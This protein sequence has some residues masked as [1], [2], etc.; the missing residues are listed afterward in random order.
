MHPS[1]TPSTE[2]VT[3]AEPRPL[4]VAVLTVFCVVATVIALSSAVSLLWPGGPLEPMWRLNPPARAGF[5]SMGP[6]AIVLLGTVAI[7]S[8]FSAVGLWRGR[9][10]GRRVVVAGIALN[11]LADLTNA[12]V[13]HDAR[14][15]IGV[16]VAAVVIAYLCS[17]PVRRYF[18]KSGPKLPA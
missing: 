15:L 16:P 14:T 9:E 13:Q 4:G 18:A 6:W 5:A 10:W 1:P 3:V 12:V 8:A 7:A 17:R 11:A 2:S